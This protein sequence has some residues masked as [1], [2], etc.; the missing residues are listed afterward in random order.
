MKVPFQKNK[1][2]DT[3]RTKIATRLGVDYVSLA[4]GY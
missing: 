4:P 1:I 3:G 2:T